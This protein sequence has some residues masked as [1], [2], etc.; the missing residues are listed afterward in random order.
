MGAVDHLLRERIGREGPLPFSAVMDAALYDPAGGF[1]SAG[2]QAGRRGDFLT[3]PEVGPLF[4]AVV[5]GA[6]D[7]WWDEFGQ[8]ATFTVVEA[9]AGPGTLARSVLAARP[10]CLGALHYVTV[11][12]SEAQRASHPPQVAARATL[13]TAD[14]P[15]VVLANELLDNLPIDIYERTADGWAELR[16][17]ERD[18]ELAGVLVPTSMPELDRLVPD[19]TPG[20]RVPWQAVAQD[21]LR[22]ALALAGADGRVVIWDYGRPTAELATMAT[23]DWLRTYRGHQR[24]GHPLEILGAQDITCEV[25]TDQLSLV[26]EPNRAGTQADWLRAHGIEALVDEARAIWQERAAKGDLEAMKARSRVNEAAALL[27]PAGLGAFV[28]LEW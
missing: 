8:P 15:C 28:A 23:E 3:S 24:G 17:T 18:G 20:A 7:S 12:R 5:A 26:R 9:G 1:Y 19:A 4:G 16:V 27:D 25:A 11:E 22:S 14:G 10:R 6:L 13:P 2:G 21:W